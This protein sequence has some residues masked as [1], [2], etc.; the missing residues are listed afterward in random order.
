MTSTL[1]GET[2]YI[3]DNISLISSENE[4][5]FRRNCKHKITFHV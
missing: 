5:C 4:K 1:H 2:K 3:Y